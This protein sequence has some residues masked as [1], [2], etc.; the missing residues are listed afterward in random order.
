MNRMAGKDKRENRKRKSLRWSMVRRLVFGWFLPLFLMI[1]G[2]I[3]LM[4]R[5]VLGQV[6]QT[7]QSS[8]EKTVEIM[9]IQLKDCETASKNASYMAVIAKYY[10]QYWGVEDR[11]EFRNSVEEFLRQQYAYDDN[12]RTAELVVLNEPGSCYYALNESNGGSYQ[13]IRFFNT[14][15]RDKILKVAET[16]DTGT[17]LVGVEGKI[18]M[19]RNLVT[20]KFEPYAVLTLELDQDSLMKSYAGIWGYADA[21]LYWNGELLVPGIVKNEGSPEHNYAYIM[22]AL[23]EKDAVYEYKGGGYSHA[24]R[25]IKTYG[26]TMVLMIS[27]DNSVTYAE[28]AVMQYFFLILFLFMIP[29]IVQMMRFFHKKVTVPLGELIIAADTVREGELGI[30]IANEEDNEEFYRMKESFNHMSLQ[31][32]NQFERIYLEEVALRD[33]KIMA[34][35]SQINPHFLNNTLE[36]INWEARLN[37]N[38]KVSGMIEALST[39]LEETMNRKEAQFHSVAEELA[40]AD[41]YLYII[42][43]RFG[44]KFSCTKQIDERLMSLQ[45]PRLIIQPIVENAVEHGMDITEQGKLELRLFERADGYLCIE[46]EDNGHLTKEDRKRIDRILSQDIELSKEKRVSLGIRNV[47]QRLK[48]IYGPDCG[49]FIDGNENDDTVSTIL[50]KMDVPSEQ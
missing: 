33:A 39:M 32:K 34:L 26:G 8:V 12:C 24:Y 27:L 29:L 37:G 1:C 13:D 15:A 11:T 42:S 6:E 43:Q 36:I 3:F 35:Q 4:T 48:M 41:A 25:R 20:A 22:D 14:K 45:V 17:T 50:L 18:Y 5:N 31:L 49:L 38:N 40:Y 47:D 16:L 46:V 2:V 44:A 7:I 23:G 9:Q 28:M 30:Q 10:R 21:A 19:V